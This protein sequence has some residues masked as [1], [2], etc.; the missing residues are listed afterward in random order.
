[1]PQ[2]CFKQDLRDERIC[3]VTQPN[4]PVFSSG[5]P[6]IVKSA[7]QKPA[8]DGRIMIE[9][10]VANV[11]TGKSRVSKDVPLDPRYDEVSFQLIHREGNVAFT[12]TSRG[13]K[14]ED[15]QPAT[16]RLSQGSVY[17]RCRSDS[18]PE[19]TLYTGQIDILLDYWYQDIIGQTIT[20]KADIDAFDGS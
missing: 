19:D 9:V 16:A 11:G 3:D 7:S 8:G 18:L 14:A 6:I 2:V 1:M 12:C 13:E 15:G 4:L 10:E 20:I 17:I 5:A